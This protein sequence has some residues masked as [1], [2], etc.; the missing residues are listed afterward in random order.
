M[1]KILL[2][3]I[4]AMMLFACNNVETKTE[5]SEEC[6]DEG[7]KCD[8]ICKEDV[9]HVETLLADIEASVDKDV[10]VCGRCIHICDHSGKNIFVASFDDEDVLIIGKAAEGVDKFDK[11]FEGGN[12]IV[13][14]VLRAAELE[15][16]EEIE[17]HHDVEITYYIEV[18]EVHQCACKHKCGD[19]DT[20]E[21]HHHDMSE[22]HHHHDGDCDGEHNHE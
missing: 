22:E 15:E 16:G 14:G 6:C 2:L 10:A 21:E 13:K 11:A 3:I 4:P 7:K 18:T 12:V 17:V 1:K 5:E 9:V 8:D 20:D 19:H